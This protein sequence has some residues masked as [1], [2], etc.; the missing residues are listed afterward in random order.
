MVQVFTRLS[1]LVKVLD[2]N[3]TFDADAFVTEVLKEV[4]S[5]R[6]ERSGFFGRKVKTVFRV[7][8]FLTSCWVGGGGVEFHLNSDQ[9]FSNLQVYG[10]TLLGNPRVEGFWRDLAQSIAERNGVRQDN[11]DFYRGVQ[12]L[13]DLSKDLSAVS[14]AS[15]QYNQIYKRELSRVLAGE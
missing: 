14:L 3:P 6:V 1:E 8:N 7:N 9:R 4:P 12:C 13:D 2:R 11:C 15:S 10:E 5:P